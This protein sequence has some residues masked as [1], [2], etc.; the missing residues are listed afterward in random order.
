M[1]RSGLN[2]LGFRWQLG[3][4][5]CAVKDTR[6]LFGVFAFVVEGAAD[7]SE[8]V[9]EGKNVA[10][11]KEIGILCPD[12]M[13][14]HTIGCNG[15]F[16]HE[17][18]S[19]NGDTLAGRAT[20]RNPADY[21]V[22]CRNLLLIEELTK[23]LS[24]GIGRNRCR[25]SHSKALRTSALNTFVCAR[26]CAGSAMEVVQLRRSAVQADLQD[27]SI[28]GQRSQALRAPPDKQ[29]SVGQHRGRSGCGARKQ[30]F[31]DIFQQKRLASGHEDFF[32][33]K[34]RRFMSD[35]L[36]SREP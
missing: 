22:F 34:P 1:K 3:R 33:A 19:A 14:V 7:R 35:P 6:Q 23:R 4:P 28:T 17:I 32:D 15:D 27:N 20:Q 25:K 30:N 18:G 10:R 24:L 36:Y 9:G 11:D 12:R 31:A 2:Q 8:G 26:P 13:P 29:H 21:S 5:S 16:R